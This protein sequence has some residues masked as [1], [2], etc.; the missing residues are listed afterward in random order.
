MRGATGSKAAKQPRNSAN[1]CTWTTFNNATTTFRTSD[2]A[3]TTSWSRTAARPYSEP[4]TPTAKSKLMI[5]T[6]H[7][8][9]P[10]DLRPREKT[11]I[12]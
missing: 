11:V 6:S 1:S 3:A 9:L 5:I 2:S 7:N 10:L 8:N 4:A 12:A